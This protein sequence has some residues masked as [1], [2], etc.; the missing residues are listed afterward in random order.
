MHYSWNSGC[1]CQLRLLTLYIISCWT[2]KTIC[3]F[4]ILS[5]DWSAIQY[6]VFR[7]D[8]VFLFDNQGCPWV[9]LRTPR[10]FP[11]SAKERPSTLGLGKRYAKG[12]SSPSSAKGRQAI[13]AGL[14]PS[15]CQILNSECLDSSFLLSLEL[16]LGLYSI[17][18]ILWSIMHFIMVHEQLPKK[19]KKMVHEL[20]L[21][22]GVRIRIIY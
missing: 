14:A 12:S 18:Y 15:S 10:L 9:S 1:Q 6:D 11:S 2:N 19:K 22:T 8:F 17:G 16:A 7:W 13:H 4:D 21:D 20:S 3:L 5:I